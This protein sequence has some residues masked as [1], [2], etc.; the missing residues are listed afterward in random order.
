MNVT[1]DLLAEVLDG[2][3]VDVESGGRILTARLR[4]P[5]VVAVQ[6]LSRL[7]GRTPERPDLTPAEAAAVLGISV[8]ALTRRAKAGLVPCKRTAEGGHRRYPAAAV[9]ELAERERSGA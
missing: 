1:P 6:V 2:L 5:R 9:R 3:A 8:A 4:S 7:E